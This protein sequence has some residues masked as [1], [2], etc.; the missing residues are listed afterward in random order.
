MDFTLSASD[1]KWAQD[2][3]EKG[4]DNDIQKAF[5]GTVA[6]VLER[7][8][9]WIKW[10]NDL[11]PLF[12]NGAMQGRSLEEQTRDKLKTDGASACLALQM[13]DRG[14][15]RDLGNGIPERTRL[16]EST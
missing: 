8:R 10:K 12:D 14:A 13:G 4:I 6:A 5:S 9:N 15:T 16:R 3:W 1:A 2:T 7:E 11:C